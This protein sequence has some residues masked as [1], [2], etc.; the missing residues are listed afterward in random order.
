[1]RDDFSKA[2]IEQLRKRVGERCSNQKCLAPTSGPQLDASKSI[3]IGVAAHIHAA[4]EGGPRYL[5]KM[6]SAERKDILNAIWLCQNCAKLIDSD[7]ERFPAELLISWKNE[8]E[9]RAFADISARQNNIQNGQKS[10]QVENE[11][12]VISLGDNNKFSGGEEEI[13]ELATACAIA[14]IEERKAE[15][16]IRLEPTQLD[17]QPANPLLLPEYEI[18]RKKKAKRFKKWMECLTSSGCYS[19]WRYYLQDVEDWKETVSVLLTMS[20]LEGLST[21]GHKVEVWRTS[22]P[23]LFGQIYLLQHE[24]EELLGH[25]GFSH[26]GELRFGAG[27]R[28]AAE[29]P[30]GIVARHVI[31]RIILELER[32]GIFPEGNVFDLYDWHIGDG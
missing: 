32:Q 14:A 2:T 20:T 30:K 6:S 11:K 9:Q 28:T 16:E 10:F 19:W 22:T 7:N 18:L 15:F 13:L 4:S 21:V 31:P 12:I 26:M 29:M 24:I 25:L 1:M 27:W 23:E 17:E 8:A 5:A 3:N